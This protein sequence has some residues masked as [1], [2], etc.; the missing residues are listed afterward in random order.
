MFEK[1]NEDRTTSR[2]APLFSIYTEELAAIIRK[3]TLAVMVN[4]DR[5]GSLPY[6]DNVVLIGENGKMLQDMINIVR[7]YG[8]E[9]SLSFNSNKCGVMICN[10]PVEGIQD[11]RLGNQLIKRVKEYKYIGILFE[12]GGTGKAKSERIFAASQW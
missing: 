1:T 4:E 6:A 2:K 7:T 10:K 11:F 5:M 12:E 8:S 3:S 9:F